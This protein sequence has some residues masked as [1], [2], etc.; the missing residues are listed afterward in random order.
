MGTVIGAAMVAQP[1]FIFGHDPSRDDSYVLGAGLSI[2]RAALVAIF[3]VL[4]AK[5]KEVQTGIFMTL[6]S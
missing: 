5:H 4:S 2:L 3:T 6:S 1:S